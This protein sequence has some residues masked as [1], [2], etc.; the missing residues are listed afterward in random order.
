MI[1][2][3]INNI[4]TI[5]LLYY[6]H[7]P[8]PGGRGALL[9]LNFI[10]FLVFILCLRFLLFP[11]NCS[12]FTWLIHFISFYIFIYFT[13]NVETYHIRLL[14]LSLKSYWKE[15][16]VSHTG[17]PTKDETSETSIRNSHCLFPF[18]HNSLKLETEPAI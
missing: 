2:P 3:D 5:K 11:P 16:K 14:F 9:P 4:F 7:Q 1:Y 15:Q 13:S 8:S 10:I 18:I 6:P 12:F 17:L